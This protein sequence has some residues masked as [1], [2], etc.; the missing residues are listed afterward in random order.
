MAPLSQ[1]VEAHNNPRSSLPTKSVGN[2]RP[3][4]R[5]SRGESIPLPYRMGAGPSHRHCS[6]SRAPLRQISLWGAVHAPG[7][8][9][10]VP[11]LHHRIRGH[12][13]STVLQ[14]EQAHPI[15]QRTEVRVGCRSVLLVTTQP[16]RWASTIRSPAV[17]WG[18]GPSI[19]SSVR[20]GAWVLRAPRRPHRGNFEQGGR[21]SFRILITGNMAADVEVQDACAC[22]LLP[23]AGCDPQKR[24]PVVRHHLTGDD[25]VEIAVLAVARESKNHCEPMT[26]ERL[27]RRQVGCAACE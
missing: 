22:P 26:Y 25:D 8:Q 21:G 12:L 23:Q 5:R 13:L 10:V 9:N 17:I 14:P 4:L 7:R 2:D 16:K 20:P 18:V 19:T 15:N 1:Q 27:T 24:L 3:T 6:S 11:R